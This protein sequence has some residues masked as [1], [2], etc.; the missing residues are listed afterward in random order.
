VE[1][2]CWAGREVA[3]FSIVESTCVKLQKRLQD[4]T[5]S[6]DAPVKPREAIL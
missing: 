5:C 1:V 4:E 3:S 6:G 2:C